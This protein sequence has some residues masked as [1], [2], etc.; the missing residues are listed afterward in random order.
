MTTLLCGKSFHKAT[1]TAWRSG[2]RSNALRDISLLP[3]RTLQQTRNDIISQIRLNH[4]LINFHQNF[5]QHVRNLRG[6]RLRQ[7]RSFMR[8]LQ[9]DFRLWANEEKAP[10]GFGKFYPKNGSKNSQSN[11]KKSSPDPANQPKDRGQQIEFKFSFGKGGGGGG[12]GGGGPMDPNFWTMVGFAGT[13]AL[14]F[15]I[16][17]FKMR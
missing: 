6:Q 8:Q 1:Q 5:I 7:F 2:L 13:L 3:K 17:T 11:Q 15:G 4:T 12:P 16:S 10:E 9:Q 14:L